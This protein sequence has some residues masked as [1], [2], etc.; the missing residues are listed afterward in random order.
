[1][2]QNNATV[3]Y[4]RSG[5]IEYGIIKKFIVVRNDEKS[6]QTIVI[7]CHMQLQSA[8]V[9]PHILILCALHLL[10]HQK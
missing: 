2:K 4:M 6:T 10:R 9:V 7:I 8:I 3:A 1:M 5:N